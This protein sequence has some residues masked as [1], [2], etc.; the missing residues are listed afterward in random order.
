MCPG[1]LFEFSAKIRLFGNFDFRWHFCGRAT[2]QDFR[3]DPLSPT[4][5]PSE[6]RKNIHRNRFADVGKLFVPYFRIRDSRNKWNTM[7]NGTLL[8]GIRE[9]SKKM[10]HTFRRMSYR[11]IILKS[12]S[13]VGIPS[14]VKSEGSRDP[15]TRGMYIFF[16]F[17]MSKEWGNKF[18]YVFPFHPCS[19]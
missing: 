4:T 15:L 12:N 18:V 19:I 11:F 5:T 1:I 7:L 17:E 13:E 16:H 9:G 10:K 6:S 14:Y 8:P 3:G 2:K